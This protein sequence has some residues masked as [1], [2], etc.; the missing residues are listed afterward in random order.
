MKKFAKLFLTLGVVSSAIAP[1]TM[2]ACGD[3]KHPKSPTEWVA[4]VKENSKFKLENTQSVPKMAVITDG[5]DLNDKSFNQSAWEGLLK[6]ANQNKLGLDKYDIFEVAGSDFSAAYNAALAGGYKY[7]VLPGFMHQA[8]IKDFYAKNKT[9]MEKAGVT[10]IALDFDLKGA[11]IPEGRGISLNFK[12]KEGGFMAGYAAA[13]FLSSNTNE[14][15]RTA[16]TFGGGDFPGVTDFNEGFLKG[17]QQWNS[18]QTDSSKK[19]K[20]TDEVIAL[21]SG[22]AP[23]DKMNSVINAVLAKN[24][25]LVLPVAGPAT[26]IMTSK[27]EFNTKY[28]IGV[29]SDQA[30]TAPKNKERFFTSILKRIGQAVYD[31][32]GG[33]LTNDKSFIGNYEEGKTNS[34]L[35]KGVKD[36]WVG[37]TDTHI[38]GDKQ[39]EAEDALNTA[40]AKFNGLN[41]EQLKWLLGNKATQSGAEIEKVVDRLKEIVK[42]INKRN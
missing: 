38:I 8:A 27:E 9:A 6:I 5:G 14:K 2:V 23:N 36:G 18:E 39:K 31:T 37:L 4:D 32:L 1:L 3:P 40:K 24:P 28:A 35:V 13:K 26:N 15:D 33:L 7:W 34:S 21:D 42:E 22:F 29:D 30:L 12:T 17:I 19:I 41:E 25:K 10:L 11:N 20:I 16:S